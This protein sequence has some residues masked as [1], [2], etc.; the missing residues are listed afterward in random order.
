MVLYSLIFFF[1]FFFCVVIG[2]DVAIQVCFPEALR[3]TVGIGGSI[4]V[5]DLDE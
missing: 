5:K 1:S 4:A 2:A 3:T